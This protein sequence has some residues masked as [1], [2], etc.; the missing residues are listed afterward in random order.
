MSRAFPGAW[1]YPR[2]V[3]GKTGRAGTIQRTD[4]ARGER[5]RAFHAGSRAAATRALRNLPIRTSGSRAY[6]HKLP[7]QS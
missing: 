4:D 3:R 2:W 7:S 1:F 5:R 6:R